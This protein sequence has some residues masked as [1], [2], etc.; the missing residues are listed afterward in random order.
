MSYYYDTYEQVSVWALFV[1]RY[2]AVPLVS[3]Y[4]TDLQVAA[5]HQQRQRRRRRKQLNMDA[6][7]ANKMWKKNSFANMLNVS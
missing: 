3:Q 1:T 6:N 4:S 2:S 5:M 7:K